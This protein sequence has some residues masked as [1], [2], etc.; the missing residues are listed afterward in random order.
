MRY[1]NVVQRRR[2][3][4]HDRREIEELLRWERK[5]NRM[6]FWLIWTH[7][8]DRDSVRNR[9]LVWL[10][11]KNLSVLRDLD[12][13]IE[14]YDVF[15]A[16]WFLSF[17]LTLKFWREDLHDLL[18]S[19]RREIN[20]RS[21]RNWIQSSFCSVWSSSIHQRQIERLDELSWTKSIVA[22]YTTLFLL[23]MNCDVP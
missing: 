13:E 18:Q 21:L 7:K 1:W 9:R 3:E 8:C 19:R 12:L 22:F 20:R 15:D 2:I 16:L 6:I 5:S 17:R 23:E 11:E 10:V 4:T 14:R